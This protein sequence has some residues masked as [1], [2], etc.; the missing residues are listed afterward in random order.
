MRWNNSVS[1]G[2]LENIWK[3]A[4][5]S[6]KLSWLFQGE[7]QLS[8][9]GEKEHEFQKRMGEMFI[10]LSG[11]FFTHLP[12][13]FCEISVNYEE[14]GHMSP[15]SPNHCVLEKFM[16]GQTEILTGQYF[17]QCPGI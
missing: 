6:A 3:N 1:P 8:V 12:M 7:S 10:V 17:L 5:L 16:K 11:D 4:L 14:Q 2:Y 13:Y 9:T 15:P